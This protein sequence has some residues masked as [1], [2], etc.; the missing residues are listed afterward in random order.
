MLGTAQKVGALCLRSNHATIFPQRKQS[1][2]A[3]SSYAES[4][5]LTWRKMI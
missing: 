1:Y 3:N 2:A 5:I 4:L